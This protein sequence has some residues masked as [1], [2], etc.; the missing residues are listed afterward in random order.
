M[1]KI[2]IRD[3]EVYYR[4]GVPEAER[5]NPQKLLLTLEL[6][7]DLS[8][9]AATDELSATVDYDALC[10]EI[11]QFGKGRSW[12]LI[13]TVAAQIADLALSRKPVLEVKVEVKK[14]I[15]P[16]A[17]YVSVILRRTRA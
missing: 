5:A 7:L 11:L 9:A 17:Q 16:Q 6:S 10:Q 8:A 3:L 12:K 13:E 4:V 14:F 15:I 2:S 1:D